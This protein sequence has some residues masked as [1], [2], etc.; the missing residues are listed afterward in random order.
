MQK[1]AWA[2][3]S[4]ILLLLILDQSLKIWVKTHMLLGESFVIT[5][6]FKISFTENPGM[7]FGLEIMD[8]LYLT[9]FRIVAVIFIGWYL[10][11]IINKRY[12]LGYVLCFSLIFV[13]AVGNI[14]DSVFYGVIFNESPYWPGYVAGTPAELP[15]PAT[16][17]PASGGYGTWLHGKV[18]DMLFFPLIDTVVPQWVPIWGGQPFIFFRPIFNIADSA[19]CVG[20]F[21]LFI[22]YR[23]TLS[24][25]L[26]KDEN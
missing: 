24:K 15:P 25:S 11:R 12:S 1:K 14:L 9:L 8:K 7:A 5:S 10:I 23:K 17:F 6:W 21:L 22:F 2:A 3:I 13:G 4:I 20:A 26:G 18:V 19:V 16:L